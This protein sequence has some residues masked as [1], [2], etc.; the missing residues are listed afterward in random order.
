MN[1]VFRVLLYH[2]HFLIVEGEVRYWGV[3]SC[4]KRVFFSNEDIWV[5]D[6]ANNHGDLVDDCLVDKTQ[7]VLVIP[8]K[9]T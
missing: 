3:F 9:G 2:L 7:V 6:L 8:Q 4:K 5:H 1:Q